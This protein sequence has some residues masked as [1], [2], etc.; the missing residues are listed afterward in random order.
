MKTPFK[1]I[2]TTSLFVCLLGGTAFAQQ[3]GTVK[4]TCVSHKEVTEEDNTGKKEVKYVTLGRALPGDVI[5][6]TITYAH[7]G[8]EPATD[9]VIT[10]PVPDNTFFIAGS[11]TGENSTIDYSVNG[12][13]YGAP[14]TLKIKDPDGKERQAIPA[15]F[16]HIR[17]TLKTPLAKGQEGTVNFK[18]RIK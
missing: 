18:V 11:A 3:K 10:N 2:L 6:Y 14:A 15:E 8:D 5:R 16:T 9:I 12:K 1:S 4:L 17:W 13:T 7:V